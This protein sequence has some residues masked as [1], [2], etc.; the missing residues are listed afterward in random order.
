MKPCAMLLTM[1]RAKSKPNV[2][3]SLRYPKDLRDKLKVVADRER[4]SLND[5]IVYVLERW[6]E[7]QGGTR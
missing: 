5:Q 4:R 6:L 7:Q 2:I 1:K 3:A